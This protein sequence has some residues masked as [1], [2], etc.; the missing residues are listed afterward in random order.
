[1]LLITVLLAAAI[2]SPQRP[3]PESTAGRTGPANNPAEPISGNCP[4]YQCVQF[5]G[6][7]R[8]LPRSGPIMKEMKSTRTIV[9]ISGGTMLRPKEART[10]SIWINLKGLRPMPCGLPP[11]ACCPCLCGLIGVFLIAREGLMSERR[12]TPLVE[13]LLHG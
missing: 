7:P 11:K 6:G 13:S 9:T 5:T 2:I 4:R 10:A 8:A 3:S 12:R 1:M